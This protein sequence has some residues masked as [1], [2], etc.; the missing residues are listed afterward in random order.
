[1]SDPAHLPS[2][3]GWPDDPPAFEAV[4]LPHLKAV[5]LL[6]LRLTAIRPPRKI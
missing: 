4:A 3:S 2:R 1:M 6:A 5:Y